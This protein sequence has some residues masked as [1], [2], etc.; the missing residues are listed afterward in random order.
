MWHGRRPVHSEYR[1]LRHVVKGTD[2]LMRWS[3]ADTLTPRPRRARRSALE[4]FWGLKTAR[5]VLPLSASKDATPHDLRPTLRWQDNIKM[6]IREI[7]NSDEPFWIVN[8]WPH[9]ARSVDTALP[10]FR[11]GNRLYTAGLIVSFRSRHECVQRAVGKAVMLQTRT[12]K[13]LGRNTGYG[14]FS[15]SWFSSVYPGE[16]QNCIPITPRPISSKCFPT[17]ITNILTLD[18]V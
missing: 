9:E 4:A 2:I 10:R 17:I 12:R 7:M 3:A 1:V 16:Y 5:A 8:N 15:F 6:D 14:D 18:P 13:M 11:H